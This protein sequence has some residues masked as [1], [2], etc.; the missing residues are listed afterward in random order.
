MTIVQSGS[1]HCQQIESNEVLI[2]AEIIEMQ[3][4]QANPNDRY[5]TLYKWLLYVSVYI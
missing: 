2:V 1:A 4:V 3:F 5:A